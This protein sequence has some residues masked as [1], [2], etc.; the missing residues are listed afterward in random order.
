LGPPALPGLPMA[1]YAAGCHGQ[2]GTKSGDRVSWK[3]RRLD[4]GSYPGIAGFKQ[5]QELNFNFVTTS[6]NEERLFKI[7]NC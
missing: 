7:F 2:I 3:L 6:A 4:G 1:S 5:M